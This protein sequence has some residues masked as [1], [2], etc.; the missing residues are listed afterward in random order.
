M[1]PLTTVVRQALINCGY[2]KGKNA[3]TTTVYRDKTLTTDK[4]KINLGC[5]WQDVDFDKI[6][7]AIHEIDPKRAEHIV[8]MYQTSSS[9]PSCYVVIHFG[10]TQRATKQRRKEKIQRA[11]KTEGRREG[12]EQGKKEGQR[13]LLGRLAGLGIDLG[14]L[15]WKAEQEAITRRNE[16]LKE[17]QEVDNTILE[18][19]EL[20]ELVK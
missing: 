9:R 12:V 20:F 7:R 2:L 3:S 4:A 15:V 11:S 6:K 1:K 16:L 13:E 5:K 18:S 17:L 19:R 8:E 10:I 14:C